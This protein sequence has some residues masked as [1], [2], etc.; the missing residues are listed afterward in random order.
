MNSCLVG[1]IWV[2][3]YVGLYI[4]CYNWLRLAIDYGLVI[5]FL[6]AL[7]CLTLHPVK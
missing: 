5:Y 6:V 4:I 2:Y 1:I 3:R 7:R